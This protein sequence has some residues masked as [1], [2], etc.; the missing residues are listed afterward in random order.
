MKKILL[1]MLFVIIALAVSAQKQ[2]PKNTRDGLAINAEPVID[3]RLIA[4]DFSVTFTD[5]TPANLYN[6]LN[7]GNTVVIDQFYTT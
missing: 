3:L 1:L 2:L 7:A 4:P 5:G 6:T